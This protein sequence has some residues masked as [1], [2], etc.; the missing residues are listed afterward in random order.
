[1]RGTRRAIA[2]NLTRSW[3]EIPHI[4]DFREVDATEL[5]AAR[6]A[7]RAE[8]ERAGD[9][10]LAR[11]LTPLALLTKI[12][13]TVARRHPRVNASVDMERE[14]ITL[15]GGIHLSIAIAAPD[16][17]V[18]PVI[19]DADRKTVPA[20]AHELVELGA[21][22]RSGRLSPAQLAGGTLTVNNFGALGSPFSTPLIPPGQVANLGLG[23][24][25]DKPV[26]RDGAVVVRRVLGISCSGDHRVL[27]GQD[28]SAFVNDVVATIERPILLLG[29]LA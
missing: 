21:V 4:V 15:H 1:M 22:A 8:A 25:Q 7:L 24:M 10:E 5:L 16:G 3:Q 27:D 11:A 9:A 19:R 29:S 23:R 18:T 17:L 26:A 12:A 20:I 28:L 2:R 6:A 13:A 14:E